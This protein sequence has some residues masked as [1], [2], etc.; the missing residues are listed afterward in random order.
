[1]TKVNLYCWPL[2]LSVTVVVRKAVILFS[3]VW[4]WQPKRKVITVSP[5]MLQFSRNTANESELKQV[6]YLASSTEV[7]KAPF[8]F[9]TKLSVLVLSL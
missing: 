9:G 2:M 5:S 4:M 7:T 6:L 3:T 8:L 1:M